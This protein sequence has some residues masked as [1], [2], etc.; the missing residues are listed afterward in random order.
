MAD[1]TVTN[2]EAA[3]RFEAQ[4]DGHTAFLEYKKTGDRILLIHTEVPPELEGK[5]VGSALARHALEYARTEQ[6]KVVP[7]CPFVAQ[8]LKRHP[9]YANVVVQNG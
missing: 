5:G 3:N 2:H 6:L 7:R 1:V 9:E 4:V 8:Y